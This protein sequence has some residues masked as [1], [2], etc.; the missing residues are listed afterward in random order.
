ML[1]HFANING[2]AGKLEE[3]RRFNN[4]N[5]IKLNILVETWLAPNASVPFRPHISNIN[6]TLTLLCVG[7]LL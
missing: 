2:L 6:L 3:V 7:G 5:N 4:N 1:I